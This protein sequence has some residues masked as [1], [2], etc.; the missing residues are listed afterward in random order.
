MP[1]EWRKHQ[2]QRPRAPERPILRNRWWHRLDLLVAQILPVDKSAEE[3]PG[4][5][6]VRRDVSVFAAGFERTPVMKIQVAI[7]AAARRGGGSAILLRA[8]HPIRKLI[9]GCHVIKLSRRLIEPRT[10]R[11]AA[12][13]RDDRPLVTA[14]NHSPRIVR[15]DPQRVVVWACRIAFEHSETFSSTD[16]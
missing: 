6:G 13:V 8:V 12:V 16:R 1:I 3:H 10:P 9:V 11:L 15:V 5:Q 4:I 2:R 14:Q 7:L